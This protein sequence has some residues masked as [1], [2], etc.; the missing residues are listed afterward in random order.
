MFK[1]LG[2]IDKVKLGKDIAKFMLLVAGVLNVFGISVPIVPA[3]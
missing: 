1:Q 2:S 3:L